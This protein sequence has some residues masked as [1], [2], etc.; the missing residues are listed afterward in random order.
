MKNTEIL[1]KK[2]KDELDAF[3]E[4]LKNKTPEAVI[5]KAELLVAMKK[6]YGYIVDHGM[7]SDSDA[8]YFLGVE[9]PL[10]GIAEYFMES[11]DNFVGFS[12]LIWE[13]TDKDLLAE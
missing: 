6:V 9:Q 13:I 7:L 3:T 5:E 10:Q 4:D 8:E 12:F 2:I 11:N 1:K